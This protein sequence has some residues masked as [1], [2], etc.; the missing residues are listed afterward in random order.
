MFPAAFERE[1]LKNARLHFSAHPYDDRL[2]IP[3]CHPVTNA[4][5]PAKRFFLT[6]FKPHGGLA[7]PTPVMSL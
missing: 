2:F 1:T 6:H 7:R 3:A 4:D 5:F